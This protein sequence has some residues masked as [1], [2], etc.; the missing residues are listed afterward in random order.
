MDEKE[1]Q[2][3]KNETEAIAFLEKEVKKIKPS[4]D[5]K[6][7]EDDFL[8]ELSKGKT[9]FERFDILTLEEMPKH[10]KYD[11]DVDNCVGRLIMLL[12]AKAE[13]ERTPTLNK[14]YRKHDK[15]FSMSAG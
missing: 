6:K 9:L 15:N 12:Y 2:K 5:I 8:K 1:L 7:F 3:C 4:F 13:K 11:W 14:I 10:C